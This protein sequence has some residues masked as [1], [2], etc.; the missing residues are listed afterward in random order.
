MSEETQNKQDDSRKYVDYFKEHH[1]LMIAS[2]SAMIT[3]ISFL[4]SLLSHLYQ[5]IILQEYNVP[6]DI[7][8]TANH[9]RLFYYVLISIA[10]YAV[11]PVI[12]EALMKVYLKYF[13]QS[14]LNKLL[15]IRLQDDEETVKEKVFNNVLDKDRKEF[16]KSLLF[17]ILALLLLFLIVYLTYS[18]ATS[19][20]NITMIVSWLVLSIVFIIFARI[21]AIKKVGEYS[22]KRVKEFIKII[23]NENDEQKRKELSFPYIDK[24]VNLSLDSMVKPRRLSDSKVFGY[25]LTIFVSLISV[26]LLVITSGY[27]EAKT[28][29]SYWIHHEGNRTYAVVYQNPEIIV[30][31]EALVENETITIV[32]NM[33]RY[34]TFEDFQ[35]EKMSFKN[36]VKVDKEIETIRLIDNTEVII[37]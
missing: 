2:I 25:L 4:I 22:P 9:G 6:L 13:R 17:G 24:L 36:V 8:N 11:V 16:K 26:V 32:R 7:I 37:S 3:F 15:R 5:K 27:I 1:T 30:L 34:V 20:F 23:E 10:F 14:A 28:R 31:E 19:S 12:Q 21:V 35:V 18:V 33:Q 29:N